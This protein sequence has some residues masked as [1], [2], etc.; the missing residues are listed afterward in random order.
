MLS[1]RG[2]KFFCIF[3]HS[4]NCFLVMSSFKILQILVEFSFLVSCLVQANLVDFHCINSISFCCSLQHYSM[5]EY[6]FDI[7]M[8]FAQHEIIIDL[9]I[10][11]MKIIVVGAL[12]KYK[13]CRSY[14]AIN[15]AIKLYILIHFF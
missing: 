15:F 13:S 2:Y 6:V 9:Y 1:S 11:L 8:F 12:E 5:M 14:I 10:I 7:Y 3:L 4:L